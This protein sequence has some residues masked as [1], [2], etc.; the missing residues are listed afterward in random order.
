M[1]QSLTV[2]P[3]LHR[4]KFWK[5]DFEMMIKWLMSLVDAQMQMQAKNYV[6]KFSSLRSTYKK[7]KTLK[8]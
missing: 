7:S 3:Q 1:F 8:V 4:V 6:S 5:F 2:L